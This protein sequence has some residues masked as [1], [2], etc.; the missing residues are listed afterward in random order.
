MKSNKYLFFFY[1]IVVVVVVYAYKSKI[2]LCTRYSKLYPKKN[3]R[4]IGNVVRV[5]SLDTVLRIMF[6]N[7]FVI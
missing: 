6:N 7:K 4:E 1:D 2:G 3:Y 5:T